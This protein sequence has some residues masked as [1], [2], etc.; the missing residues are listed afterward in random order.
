[1]RY[2]WLVFQTSAINLTTSLKHTQQAKPPYLLE[3]IFAPV[4]NV[5]E[6][7]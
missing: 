3:D 6:R 4:S 1:M 5:A 7:Q 2:A